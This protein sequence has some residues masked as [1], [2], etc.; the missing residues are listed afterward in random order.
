MSDEP[1][2]LGAIVAHPDED[3]PRLAYADWL[4]EFHPAPVAGMNPRAE[5]IRTQIELARRCDYDTSTSTTALRDRAERLLHEH[6]REWTADFRAAV[7]HPEL[8]P[9]FRRG[10]PEHVRIPARWFLDCGEAIRRTLP[11][12]ASVSLYRLNGWGQ[13]IAQLPHL[14]GLRELRV[15]CWIHESD[16]VALA[17]SQHLGGLERLTLWTGN[18]FGSST[19]RALGASTAW[20]R[21]ARVEL[22][23]VG[24]NYRG[25]Y[26]NEAAG[27]PLAVGVNP[28][29]RTFPF[30]ANFDHTFFV[31]RLPDG[32]QTFAAYPWCGVTSI[33]ALLFDAAGTPLE[34]REVPIPAADVL[35]ER[36]RREAYEAFSARMDATYRRYGE[37][38]RTHLSAEP[39]DIRVREFAIDQDGAFRCGVGLMCTHAE[40]TVYDQDD[41]DENPDEAPNGEVFGAGGVV[42]PW[43]GDH[44][45]FTFTPGDGA[46]TWIMNGRGRI[47]ST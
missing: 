24:I 25:E 44:G 4:D 43:L 34:Q 3:A 22:V 11:V 5:L 23:W 39:A 40:D 29:D 10:F 21:L 32:R 36:G 2:L 42:E 1:A 27:R 47:A 26:A 16:A 9:E 37:L 30:A 13:R 6:S 38:V 33:P 31:G 28:R 45:M 19:Y 46:D 17:N 35:R 41:P 18:W 14:R 15:P 12:L 7:P 20:P 8:Q